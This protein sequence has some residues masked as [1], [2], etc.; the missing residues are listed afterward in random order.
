MS[1]S[2]AWRVLHSRGTLR[3]PQSEE[4]RNWRLAITSSME[5]HGNAV[6]SSPLHFAVTGG[7][8][9]MGSGS[10]RLFRDTCVTDICIRIL[11]IQSV[12]VFT[13]IRRPEQ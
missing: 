3:R 10:L 7:W 8:S 2:R 13:A 11:N 6:R 9:G 12:G 4:D 1:L 5:L